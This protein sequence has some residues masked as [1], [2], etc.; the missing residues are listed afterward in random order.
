MAD[1]FEKISMGMLPERAAR[2]FGDREALMFKGERWSFRQ[3]SERVDRVAKGLMALGVRPGEKVSL[4]VPNRAEYIDLFFGL[5]K[6]GAVI[7]PVNTMFRTE[8]TAYLLGQ[9][10]S[11]T[12]VAVDRSGPIDYLAMVREM[13]PAME[14]GP[15][16]EWKEAG[17]PDLERV[18]LM[19][20]SNARGAF[21][22]SELLQRGEAIDDEDLDRR[23]AAVDPDATVMIMYTSG[24]T[25][26]PKGVMHCHNLIRNIT[27]RANRMAVTPEDVILMYLPLF[28]AF[29]LYEGPM[30][31][32]ISG[33]RQV[34]TERFDPVE[35]VRLIEAE[36][37]TLIN[38]FETHFKDLVEAQEKEG[39]DMGSLRSGVFATGTTSAAAVARK[40]ERVLCAGLV[41][42][43]G[44]SEIGV[45]AG[46]SFL[47]STVEQRCDASGYPAPGYEFRIADP[48]TGQDQP[49]G[50]PGEILIRGFGVM[51]GYYRKPEETEKTIDPEGWLHSGDLGLMREDGHLRF[52]GRIK[53]MIKTGGENV[54][55]ME[56][57]AFLMT[58]PAVHQVA[59]VGYP[60]E[61]LSEVGA[62]F[63]RLAPD[64][65][66]T[67][68]EVFAFCKG[69][70]ATFKI[71]RH[72]IF[73]Q[74]FPMTSSGKVRKVRL[75]EEALKIVPGGRGGA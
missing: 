50:R 3:V 8:D 29:G 16:G 37:A 5:A 58:H 70:I 42:G 28:H 60:D 7:V 24:T 75:K 65:E 36:R 63:I 38:G 9:S 6:I 45:G 54:D 23:A 68:E 74:D 49:A 14:S 34:L 53:E 40:A 12:L 17:F 47:N 62:A 33:A 57:E 19:G 64:R 30:L 2:R 52:I 46:L 18:V 71:P 59:V 15:A 11:G 10:N 22:W 61:R 1:W 39:R 21:S 48:V 51:Q 72:V 67:P 56:V 20:E 27:D 35:C 25:G 41:S 31:S 66:L 13:L 69:R 32:L 55:P 4:W 43:Y 73:V 26:F 44:M